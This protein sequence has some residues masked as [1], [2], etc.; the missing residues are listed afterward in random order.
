MHKGHWRVVAAFAGLGLSFWLF[1]C[2]WLLGASLHPHEQKYQPYAYATAHPES[3]YTSGAKHTGGIEAPQY[4]Q[5]CSNPKGQEESDL[6]AQWKAANAAEEGALWA[7]WGVWIAGASTI[8]VAIA[9]YLTI[10]ANS[11]SRDTAKRQL[12]AYIGMSVGG[13]EHF[14]THDPVIAFTMTNSGETPA[15]RFRL[16]YKVDVCTESERPDIPD[17]SA[18]EGKPFEQVA[19]GAGDLT[20]CW[21]GKMLT[22]KLR[23]DI[24][25]GRLHVYITGI[26]EY[27]DAFGDRYLYRFRRRNVKTHAQHGLIESDFHDIEEISLPRRKPL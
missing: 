1:F 13:I 27:E 17:I 10:E 3:I 16:I 2:G 20:R 6:C 11:I 7:K 8:A 19:P 4:R 24:Y 14:G 22:R 21:F 26:A 9:I 18:L 25:R 15:Y 23:R 5:P 12:R